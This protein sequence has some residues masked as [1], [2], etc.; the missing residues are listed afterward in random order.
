MD[1]LCYI[2]ISFNINLIS[3]QGRS[4]ELTIEYGTYYLKQ[5]NTNID[6]AVNILQM[7]RYRSPLQTQKHYA[8]PQIVPRFIPAI[9]K[10]LQR[11]P[12]RSIMLVQVPKQLRLS[13]EAIQR[14]YIKSDNPRR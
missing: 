14:G 4:M 9:Q 11:Q 1:V 5:Q 3:T 13:E 6:Y 2:Q 12:Q 7:F 8:L 10:Q